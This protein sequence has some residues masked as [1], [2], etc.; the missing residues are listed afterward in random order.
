MRHLN[1]KR[2]RTNVVEAL[3]HQGEGGRFFFIHEMLRGEF[4]CGNGGEDSMIKKGQLAS[5]LLGMEIED[6]DEIEG[7]GA[8]PFRG[9]DVLQILR[10]VR[11]G[12][13]LQMNQSDGPP[14]QPTISRAPPSPGGGWRLLSGS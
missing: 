1:V 10:D 4:L 14:Q 5:N 9:D 11:L 7:F 8:F 2:R 12:R 6:V 13:F 3:R